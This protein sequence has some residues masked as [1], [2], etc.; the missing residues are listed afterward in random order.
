MV[1]PVLSF[2]KFKKKSGKKA[3]KLHLVIFFF[4]KKENSFGKTIV[5]LNCVLF[6]SN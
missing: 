6:A 5:Q 2:K 1:A 4:E 3:H